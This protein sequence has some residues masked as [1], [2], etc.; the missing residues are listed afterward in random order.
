[1]C[2]DSARVSRIPL[3][4]MCSSFGMF[5]AVTASDFVRSGQS[6]PS[7]NDSLLSGLMAAEQDPGPDFRVW[8]TRCRRCILSRAKRSG[9]WTRCFWQSQDRFTAEAG[10][11]AERVEL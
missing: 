8:R 2:L 10:E 11:D 3:E 6:A 9:Y 1:M 7:G 4:P 5:D